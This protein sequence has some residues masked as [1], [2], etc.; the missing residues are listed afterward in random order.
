MTSQDFD[1]LSR[2]DREILMDVVRTFILKGAPVSSRSVAKH[3]QHGVSAAT[4]RN[5]MAELE[6][7]GF[8][9]QPHTSAGRVPTAAGY[10]YY[11]DSLQPVEHPPVDE[12]QYIEGHLQGAIEQGDNVVSVAGQ[13]LSELSHQV[14]VILTPDMGGT[15]LKAIEFMPLSRSRV[16]CVLVSTSGFVDQKVVH[17]EAALPREELVRISNYL[18]ENFG[19][20]T[21]RQIRG[22]LLRRMTEERT[23][24]D[25]LLSNAITLARMAL[26]REGG[27]DLLVEGTAGLLDQPELGSV[28]RVRWLLDMFDEKARMVS[29]L[30]R[31]IE[32]R[33]VR[34]LIGD[35]SDLTSELDFSLVATNYS[36]GGRALGSLGVFG[37]S[38]MPYQRMIP[39]VRYLGETLGQ[40]LEEA[41]MGEGHRG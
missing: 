29:L 3:E 25:E 12:R 27:Q 13:L 35:D 15:V 18:T 2:R 31:I 11:I 22:R 26:K 17:T 10:H 4:I 21:L 33:G 20:L 14:G 38:R 23:E 19:G 39:L 7:E 24:V 5:T 36:V 34:V 16:L 9:T 1:K 41:Y 8:L 6:E 30:S 40:A 37:P 32:G 28:E